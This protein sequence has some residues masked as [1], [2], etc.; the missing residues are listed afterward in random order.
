MTGHKDKS[1]KKWIITCKQVIQDERVQKKLR[2]SEPPESSAVIPVVTQASQLLASQRS[3][4]EIIDTLP[5]S[6]LGD[7]TDIAKMTAGAPTQHVPSLSKGMAYGQERLDL[8]KERTGKKKAA[9]LTPV[10]VFNYLRQTFIKDLSD[11]LVGLRQ[12]PASSSHSVCKAVSSFDN[13]TYT[14]QTNV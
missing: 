6:P 8:F 7:H 14:R 11:D 5:R 10:S 13:I 12:P 9:K 2:L 4:D 1:H 3:P